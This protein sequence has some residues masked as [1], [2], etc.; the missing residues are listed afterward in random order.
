MNI[1]IKLR[2]SKYC[3]GCPCFVREE[4]SKMPLQRVCSLYG[5]HFTYMH[6]TPKYTGHYQFIRPKQCIKENGE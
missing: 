2:N 3:D 5:L 6:I 4:N 1:K